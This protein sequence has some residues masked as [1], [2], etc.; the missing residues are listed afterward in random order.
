M[1]A[2]IVTKLK[3][4]IPIQEMPALVQA[5]ADWREKYRDNMESFEFFIGGGGC[6]IVNFPDESAMHQFWL[7]YPFGFFSDTEVHPIV[8]GDAALAQF[9]GMIAAM[10]QQA[11]AAAA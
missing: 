2:L 6:G 3:F 9:Q 7:E 4:F 10:S 8:Q 1:R 11:A 5:F